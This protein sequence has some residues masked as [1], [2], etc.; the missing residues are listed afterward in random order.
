MW[1]ESAASWGGLKNFGGETRSCNFP[2]EAILGAQSL[3]FARGPKCGVCSENRTG[4]VLQ[5]LVVGCIFGLNFT[6][7]RKVFRQSKILRGI[8]PL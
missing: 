3:I 5:F 4:K 7:K 6:K 8:C 1:L 2:T